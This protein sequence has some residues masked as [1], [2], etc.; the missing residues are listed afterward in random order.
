[1]AEFRIVEV[2]AERL[3][4]LRSLWGVLY[5]HHS[6]LAPQLKDRERTFEESWTERR[7][8]EQHW[9]RDEPSSFVLAAEA[10][11]R[12]IGYA[13]VRIRPGGDFSASWKV[14]D[15]VAELATLVV[16]PEHRGDGI[17]SA[18]IDAVELRLTEIDV[19]DM[20]VGVIATNFEAI[21]L[22]EKRGAVPF[23][24]ELL[25]RIDGRG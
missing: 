22:Y 25:L 19:P 3:D 12:F 15:P 10:D 17:G 24:T 1:M 7:R 9:L 21:R 16:Q 13:F 14:S 6:A 20:A 2:P 23:V 5:S 4:R 18:L 11:E 8:I